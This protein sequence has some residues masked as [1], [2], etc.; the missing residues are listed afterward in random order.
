MGPLSQ[1]T[2]N[3]IRGKN[4]SHTH[5]PYPSSPD[6]IP[7]GHVSTQEE[8]GIY[9]PEREPSPETNVAASRSWTSGF[10]NCENTF[11]LFKSLSLWYFVTAAQ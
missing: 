9:K 4:L 7:K 3:F 2:G 6:S 1:R 5:A 8:G 11:L 10:Q